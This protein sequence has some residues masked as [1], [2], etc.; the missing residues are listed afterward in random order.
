M[1]LVGLTSGHLQK[2]GGLNLKGRGDAQL[3]MRL[4]VG[5]EL[6]GVCVVN[7]RQEGQDERD[8]TSNTDTCSIVHGKE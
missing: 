2:T 4:V 6:W 1:S 8:L 7:K 3:P 5:C